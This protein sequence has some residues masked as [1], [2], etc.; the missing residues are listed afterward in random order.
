MYKGVNR[1]MNSG[2][3]RDTSMSPHRMKRPPKPNRQELLLAAGMRAVGEET[4]MARIQGELR[5]LVARG[6][7]NPRLQADML[8]KTQVLTANGGKWDAA[9]I[10]TFYERQKTRRMR[11]GSIQP[12][13]EPIPLNPV[14]PVLTRV[15]VAKLKGLSSD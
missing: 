7:K 8:N 11:S 3:G 12:H 2:P 6:I 13:R 15:R 10:V 5:K 14:N 1:F 4:F 9:C